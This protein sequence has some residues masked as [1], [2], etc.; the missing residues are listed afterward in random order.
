MKAIKPNQIYSWD[1]TYLPTLV[2]GNY[3]YLY[4]VLDIF[5][6]KIVGWQV[7]DRE[8]AEHASD[9]LKEVCFREGIAKGQVVLHS[10]NGKPMKGSAMIATLQKLG[11]IPSFSRPSVSDD[12]PYSEAL[13]RT[14]KYVPFY[15]DKPFESL[16]EARK[17]VDYFVKWYNKTHL[18]SAIGFGTPDSRHKEVG[19]AILEFRKEVY[20][21][22]KKL[23]PGRWSKQIRSW[24]KVAEVLLNPEKCTEGRVITVSY[25]DIN[26]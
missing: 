15:P 7:Y 18:H 11:V 12:N 10:D 6:R 23:N 1:I 25:G 19:E 13:F 5:S 3:F 21:K 24:K 26:Q 16:S 9:L 4:L 8:S 14:V 20:Q 17:R 2:R 22:A